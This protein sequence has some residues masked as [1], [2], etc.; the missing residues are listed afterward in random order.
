MKNTYTL[1]DKIGEQI[2]TLTQGLAVVY[3]NVTYISHDTVKG[4]LYN[5]YGDF[6]CTDVVSKFQIFQ[7]THV[8]DFAR[9]FDAFAQEYDPFNNF[10]ITETRETIESHGK[11][12]DTRKTDSEHNTVTAAALNGTQTETYT[13]TDDSDTPRLETRDTSA[14]G[15]ETT[16]DLWTTNEKSRDTTTM[17]VNGT[18]YTAHDIHGERIIKEGDTGNVTAQ[19]MLE[20]ER[21]LRLNPVQQNFL[22][23][24]IYSYASYV[25]GAWA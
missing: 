1:A 4:Y 8:P 17:T 15:T 24:F 2:K 19:S 23:L 3:G 5:K 25:G 10:S 16:D 12:T 13:T 9:A 14:G 6:F 7:S 22:D 18:E 20:E 11:T 21:K